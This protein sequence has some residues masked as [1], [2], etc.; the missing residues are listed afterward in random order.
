MIKTLAALLANITERAIARATIR[1][2]RTNYFCKSHKMLLRSRPM[3]TVERCQPATCSASTTATTQPA[4]GQAQQADDDE[5]LV[6][7]FEKLKGFVTCV[8]V[9]VRRGGCRRGRSGRRPVFFVDQTAGDSGADIVA[10]H[11]PSILSTARLPLVIITP[12]PASA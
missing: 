4:G 10:F 11:H 3:R 1:R 12:P 2:L 7:P 5:N 8:K 9:L 6:E